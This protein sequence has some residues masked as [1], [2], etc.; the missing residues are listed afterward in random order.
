MF[1]VEIEKNKNQI[2]E[3]QIYNFIKK[4]IEKKKE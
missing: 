4:Q 2:H 3:I 1:K